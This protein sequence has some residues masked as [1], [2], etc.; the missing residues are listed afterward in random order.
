EILS[1]HRGWTAGEI[2]QL[3]RQIPE[4]SRARLV[5]HSGLAASTVAAR[6]EQ[7]VAIGLVTQAEN[8]R[9]GRNPRLLSVNDRFGCVGAV[10]IGSRHARLAIVDMSGDVIE[11]EELVVPDRA[12][13]TFVRWLSE[14]I[15]RLHADLRGRE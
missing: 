2:L 10:D 9:G 6:V 13:E 5:E 12:P 1:G 14:Q 15:L 3:V 4:P 8:D 11:V 7:F